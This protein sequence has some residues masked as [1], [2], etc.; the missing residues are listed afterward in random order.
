MR[1]DARQQIGRYS[2]SDLFDC[3]PQV[4]DLL[5]RTCFGVVR[6]VR[7]LREVVRRRV[8]ASL[9]R[10]ER[11]GS[12]AEYRERNEELRSGI[13]VVDIHRYNDLRLNAN[14]MN[15]RRRP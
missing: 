1:N 6:S 15:L 11:E 5:E 2:F 13:V 10:A 4:G 12:N 14:R 7:L 9:A 8:R 3:L